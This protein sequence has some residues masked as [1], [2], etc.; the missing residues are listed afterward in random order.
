MFLGKDPQS[1]STLAPQSDFSL[2][3]AL[4]LR[5]LFLSLITFSVLFMNE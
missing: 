2:D 5:V 3:P 4:I 1:F